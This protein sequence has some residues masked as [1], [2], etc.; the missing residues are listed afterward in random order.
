M[1][2]LLIFAAAFLINTAHAATRPKVEVSFAN[3]GRALVEYQGE[4][5][6]YY[7]NYHAVGIVLARIAIR[8][9]VNCWFS[10]KDSA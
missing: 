2:M 6:G 3:Y 1:P 5:P 8:L 10:T 9:G 7:Y 4:Q